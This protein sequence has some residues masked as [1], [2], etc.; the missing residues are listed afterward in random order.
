MDSSSRI[1]DARMEITQNGTLTARV[2]FSV[3]GGLREA[4]DEEHWERAYKEH[5]NSFKLKFGVRVYTKDLRKHTLGREIDS[6]RKASI[7][8]TRN[9]KLVNPMKDKRIWVQVAKN[10]EPFV[11]LTVGDVQRELFDFEEEIAIDAAELGAG[12][13]NL[14]ADISVAWQKHVYS[15]PES[16]KA[17]VSAS[18]TIN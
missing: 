11:A 3:R 14:N 17:S 1:D 18:V 15:E 9:P 16:H 5:D 12:T 10:F 2:G 8:W 13:H 7:F 6:Y 4:F